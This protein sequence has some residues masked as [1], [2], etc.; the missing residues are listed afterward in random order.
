MNRL[1]TP[2]STRHGTAAVAPADA[3]LQQ[4]AS[5][6]SLGPTTD[7]EARRFH[8]FIISYV[9]AV[10]SFEVLFSVTG[11]PYVDR[12]WS[13]HGLEA[14]KDYR[15]QVFQ[16][17]QRVLATKS[18]QVGSS[19]AYGLT[20]VC[21]P[22]VCLDKVV[23]VWVVVIPQDHAS[24]ALTYQ[25]MQTASQYYS[26]WH[27]RRMAS[28]S[29]M[30]ADALERIVDWTAAIQRCDSIAEAAH[31]LA[32]A[33]RH[34]PDVLYT[35]IALPGRGTLRVEALAGSGRHTNTSALLTALRQC[36]NESLL[37]RG[38]NHWP[39][40]SEQAGHA[41][42][43]HRH[44]A[45]ALGARNIATQ[46]LR[47][48]NGELVGV[49]VWCEAEEPPECQHALLM[50]AAEI[51]L[52]ESLDAVHRKQPGQIRRMLT[53]AG[54]L[55]RSTKGWIAAAMLITL[56]ASMFLPVPYRVRCDCQLEPAV[57]RF[58][59]APFDGI[60][61]QGF[62]K[63]GDV[64]EKGQ[65]LARMDGR[66]LQWEL[67]GV[68]A[69]RQRA[70]K[71]REV[72]I[73][74]ERVPEAIMSALQQQQ[75]ASRLELL[76]HRTAQ[77]EIRAGT[78]GFVLSGD[79]DANRNAPVKMGDPL[80]EIGPLSPV[81]MVVRIPPEDIGYVRQG[82]S[83]KVWLEG[84]PWEPIESSISRL[85][86]RSQLVD[87]RNVFLAEVELDNLEAKLRPGMR[88]VVRIT[89]DAFPLGWNLFHKPWEFLVTRVGW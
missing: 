15:E 35:A 48:R 43:A 30:E 38:G 87:S 36:A 19:E 31:A 11:E 28:T 52:G 25:H 4:F 88:G 71:Q 44:A 73:V 26:L 47:T 78:D 46:Q 82:A 39:P 3:R 84:R 27:E 55:F 24:G 45:Q 5:R 29:S 70:E 60:V 23:R 9:K 69:E 66:E 6:F 37:H 59:V 80:Y 61:Q 21:A 56:A 54:R 14:H 81:K 63:S 16:W 77:L 76:Q 57:R 68:V 40:S 64:V 42:L 22:V 51:P 17:C 18:V 83:V 50:K 7:A 89:C 13:D 85:L 74:D 65:L 20:T 75:L 72:H 12:S 62:V 10:G 79:L 58:A 32:A 1:D 8:A 41:L 33:V 67:A 34:L 86:P 49:V 53:C 2:H